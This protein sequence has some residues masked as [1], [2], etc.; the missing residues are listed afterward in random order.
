MIR[1]TPKKERMR[2]HCHDMLRKSDSLPKDATKW[3]LLVKGKH[4]L[5]RLLSERGCH[6]LL[7][8][9]CQNMEKMAPVP[10][11]IF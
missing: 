7:H 9:Y 5:D 6:D 11:Y 10:W 4:T 3:S 8:S 1:A 2:T